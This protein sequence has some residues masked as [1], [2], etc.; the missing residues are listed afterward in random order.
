MTVDDY[1]FGVQVTNEIGWGLSSADFEFMMELEPKGCF[2]LF[3]GLD[4]VGIATTVSFGR[5]GWFGNLIVREKCR[6][7]GA[8]SLLVEHSVK[9]LKKRNVETVGLYA[10]V[11]RVP[12]YERLGFRCDLEFAVVKGK[13]FSSSVR[14]DIR[15]VREQDVQEIVDY[16]C[17]CFGSNRRRLLEPII[18][19]SDNVCYMSVEDGRISGYSVAKVYRKMAELGPLICRK[20]RSDV[21]VDLLKATLKSLEGLEVS[22]CVSRK[23]SA[24]LRM[25]VAS[26]FKENFRVT[27]MFLGS[28]VAED[29]IYIAESL[30]RG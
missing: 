9:Y 19:D 11:D 28:H 25:L 21:A 1:A 15:R 20:E 8:G 3:D 29:C 13:G 24:I 7:R 16:D 6:E 22:M 5:M 27:R 23:E 4:R 14:A 26:G 30:E 10:Y 12:F 2:V 17:I 18:K